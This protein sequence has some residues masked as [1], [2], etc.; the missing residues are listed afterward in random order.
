MTHAGCNRGEGNSSQQ[1][2]LLSLSLVASVLLGWQGAT[3]K[4]TWSR[5]RL[6]FSRRLW[7]PHNKL[8]NPQSAGCPM[9]LTPQPFSIFS[10]L[11]QYKM[12][13]TGRPVA[14]QLHEIT[15]WVS[16]CRQGHKGNQA[17]SGYAP[18]IA[19]AQLSH[20]GCAAHTGVFA[21]LCLLHCSAAQ[22]PLQPCLQVLGRSCHG[23]MSR[24]HG[25]QNWTQAWR[26]GLNWDT[27]LFVG[28]AHP[29]S[30]L[31]THSSP[32]RHACVPDPAAV[33]S[34]HQSTIGDTWEA[35]CSGAVA[36]HAQPVWAKGMQR[37]GAV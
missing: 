8:G 26:Q 3:V 22:A 18:K 30:W 12:H 24:S 17:L 5:C 27:D 1:L 34:A 6:D 37:R 35:S 11:K 4:I 13:A 29:P 21:G 2:H 10:I 14:K 16:G 23:L 36:N 15:D 31:A 32:W 9:A 19:R 33:Q 28:W 25:G 7:L 20:T